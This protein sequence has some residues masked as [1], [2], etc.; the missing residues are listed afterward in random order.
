MIRKLADAE[1]L[2]QIP[3]ARAAGKALQKEPWWPVHVEWRT[4]DDA[5]LIATRSGVSFL[6]PRQ[7]MKWLKNASSQQLAAV[8]LAGEGVRWDDLDVDVSV[9]GL[10][11]DALG[12]RFSTTA[13]GTIGG[14]AKTRAKAAAARANGAKGG[15]P[16]KRKAKS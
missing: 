14:R 3:A 15:R 10:L 7:R 9:R 13:A 1:I 16:R 11:A 6:V 5:V 4:R 12:P 2:D 8:E